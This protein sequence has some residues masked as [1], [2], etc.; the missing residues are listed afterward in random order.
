ML[1]VKKPADAGRWGGRLKTD[2]LVFSFAETLSSLHLAH[3]HGS[4]AER[5]VDNRAPCAL[6]SKGGFH[7]RPSFQTASK[8]TPYP[9]ICRHRQIF[10]HPDRQKHLD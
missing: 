6:R 9:P 4:N 1:Q 3:R 2:S 5:A 8:S 7:T 10:R